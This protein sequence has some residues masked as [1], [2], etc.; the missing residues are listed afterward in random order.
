MIMFIM[1]VVRCVMNCLCGMWCGL[2]G[3]GFNYYLVVD[4]VDLNV[5]N[6]VSLS[7]VWFSFILC[8]LL[9]NILVMV[10]VIFWFLLRVCIVVLDCFVEWFWMNICSMLG[11]WLMRLMYFLMLCWIILW[12]ELV[13]KLSDGKIVVYSMLCSCILIV[14]S[15]LDLL[16]KCW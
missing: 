13:V 7:V 1:M 11:C 8:S 9:L 2:L 6:V 3:L 15:K 10:S 4:V 12:V 5:V 16:V 14:L